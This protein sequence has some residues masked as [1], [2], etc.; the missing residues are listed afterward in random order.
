MALRRLPGRGPL[1]RQPGRRGRGGGRVRAGDQRCQPHLDG[2]VSLQQPFLN[3][4]ARSAEL[5][6]G[7]PVVLFIDW[8]T[9][10]SGYYFGFTSQERQDY[11]RLYA[12]EAYANGLF[13]AFFLDDTLVGE[14]PY[15]DQTATTLGLMPFFTGLTAFYRGHASFYHGV[16]P[17]AVTVTTSLPTAMVAVSDQAMPHRRLVHLVNHE[18]LGGIVTQS[19]VSVS[20]PSSAAPMGV[21]LASPDAVP[22]GDVVLPFTYAGGVVKVTVPSLAAYAIVVV[23]Y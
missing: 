17:A 16:Q 7:A 3:L 2:T 4:K 1:Q 23:S 13:F 6:P 15:T 9:T 22:P 14:S 12:A 19:N 21:T 20:I 10:F 5:A 8:P 11:W 18:Y